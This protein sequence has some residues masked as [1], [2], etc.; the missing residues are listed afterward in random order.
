VCLIGASPD[1]QARRLDAAQCRVKEG[2][3]AKEAEE[4]EEAEEKAAW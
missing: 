2:E 1:R 4:A 3:E